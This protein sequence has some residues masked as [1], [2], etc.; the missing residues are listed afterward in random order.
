MELAQLRVGVY[1]SS[2]AT[3]H[4]RVWHALL[5][6]GFHGSHRQFQIK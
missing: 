2:E 4:Y 5:E 3:G 6:G 1:G